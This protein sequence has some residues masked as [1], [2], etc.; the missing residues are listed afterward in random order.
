[1]YKSDYDFLR[2]IQYFCHMFQDMDRYIFDL[3]ML[4]LK[5]IQSLWYIRVYMKGEHQYIQLNMNI[6]L[7]R[8]LLYI[9]Y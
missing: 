6:L 7:V 5:D 1:M 8:S 3:N 4:L 2:D 9:D